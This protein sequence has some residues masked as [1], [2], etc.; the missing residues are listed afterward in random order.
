[1]PKVSVVITTYNRARFI[2]EAIKSVLTQSFRDFEIIVVD[3]GSKDNTADI[4]REFPVSYYYQENQGI[5]GAYNRGIE[6][7]KGE[8]IDFLDSDDSFLPDALA[9]GVEVLNA[10]PEVGF[11]YGRAYLVDEDGRIFGLKKNGRQSG[12]RQG[13]Q[14]IGDLIYGNYITSS[15]VMLRSS[16]L[17]EIGTFDPRFK[18]GSEDF[19]LWTRLARKFAVGY[20]AEPLVKFRVHFNSISVSRQVKEIERSHHLILDSIFNDPVVGPGL[21]ACHSKAYFF[22]D[23]RL[24]EH[25]TD[26][27]DMK[28]ARNYLF[29]AFS[30]NTGQ[31]FKGSGLTWLVKFFKALLPQKVFVMMRS[32]KNFIMRQ[33]IKPEKT[34]Q[35]L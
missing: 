2:A 33:I 22:L 7:A 18:S 25:A 14:E 20:I 27:G 6:L 21:R 15:T 16:C 24:A 12:V 4:V 3:D 1:M 23:L 17:N 29:K 13:S 19:E 10:H 28:T 8:Y 35:S 31:F 26:H 11:S 34:S 5:V 30:G 32:C 9:K